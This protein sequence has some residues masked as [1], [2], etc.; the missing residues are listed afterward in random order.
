[1]SLRD[2]IPA[3]VWSMKMHRT[4]TLVEKTTP[5][6]RCMQSRGV[7]TSTIG[8]KAFLTGGFLTGGSPGAKLS[9]S[10]VLLLGAAW[11]EPLR[12]EG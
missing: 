4:T 3:G 8:L 7:S 2:L 1:M 11:G 6:A 9:A 12:T 5:R 10:P